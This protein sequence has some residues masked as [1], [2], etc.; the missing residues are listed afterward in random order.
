MTIEGAPAG[1]VMATPACRRHPFT[2]Q[3]IIPMHSFS[4]PIPL[5]KK[6]V[7][8]AVV[9]AVFVAMIAAL[10]PLDVG[11]QTSIRPVSLRVGVFASPT[12]LGTFGVARAR[13][14]PAPS[15]G[16][17]IQQSLGRSRFSLRF[18]SD[19]AVAT[20]PLVTAAPGCESDCGAKWSPTGALGLIAGDLVATGGQRRNWY[21]AFG[22]GVTGTLYLPLSVTCGVPDD[23]CQ[24]LNVFSKDTFDPAWH[25]ALGFRRRLATNSLTFEF[26]DYVSRRERHTQHSLLLT[27]GFSL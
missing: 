22:G 12:Q 3:P 25:A 5:A 8:R 11:A 13:Q 17:A 27:V 1:N 20:G 23:I 15:V 18:T 9:P 2:Q 24:A 14:A 7:R 19:V 4:S 10:A 16:V 26:G 21:A 6:D